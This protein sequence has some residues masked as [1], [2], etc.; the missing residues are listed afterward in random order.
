MFDRFAGG[1]LVENL[2]GERPA[3]VEAGQDRRRCASVEPVRHGRRAGRRR[4]GLIEDLQLRADG[5]GGVGEQG[6]QP[7]INRAAGASAG[8]VPTGLPAA[9]AVAPELRVGTGAGR[10][11]RM[12]QGAA[13]DRGDLAAAGAADPA[14]LAGMTPRHAGGLG[15]HAGGVLPA[16]AAAQDGVGQAAR[17]ERARRSSC[18]DRASSVAGDAEFLV[19]RVG[20]QAVRTQRLAQLVPGGGLADGAA[21]RARLGPGFGHAVAAE[22][23]SIAGFDQRENA[24]AVRTRGP[25]D[26]AC[27]G[28]A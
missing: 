9:W 26:V 24:S 13:A 28:I 8:P 18:A 12:I 22:P 3:G 7:L 1:Q 6:A 27:P 11:E 16:D 2:V 4:E 17:A 20:D 23:H 5:A 25:D 15:D 21:T 19:G 14:L 10:A